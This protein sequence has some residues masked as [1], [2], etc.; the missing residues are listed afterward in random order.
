MEEV[1]NSKPNRKSI[2][3]KITLTA[4]FAALAYVL[5]LIAHFVPIQIVP[6]V[7]FLKYDPKDILICIAGFIMGPFYA[8]GVSVVVSFIEMITISST[9]FYGFIMNVISTCAFVVPASLIYRYKKSFTGALISLLVG[10]ISA[11]IVMTLWNII[12]TPIYMNV[13]RDVLVKNYLIPIIIFNAV[14]VG[15]NI[16]LVLL[17]YKP[18]VTALRAIRLT[19]SAK[20][21]FDL[22]STLIMCGIGLVLLI[23]LIITW[24]LLRMY[25]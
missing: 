20:T 5:A 18:L 2:V 3:K 15:V 7:G 19:D 9:A 22:K 25:M 24:I 13:P 12:I 10:F 4:M 23:T 11:I 14:K 16:A 6:S 8:I 21:K 17:L 1:V